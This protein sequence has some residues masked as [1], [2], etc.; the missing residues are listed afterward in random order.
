MKAILKSNR[1]VIIDVAPWVILRGEKCYKDVKTG[2]VY[3]NSELEF[4]EYQGG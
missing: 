3:L 4:V 2:K 1:K